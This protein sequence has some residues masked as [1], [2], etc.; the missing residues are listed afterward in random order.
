[1]LEVD[2]LRLSQ[3]ISNLLINAGKYTERAGRIT[4]TAGREGKEVV[5]RV[6][7]TGIGIAPELLPR[8]FDLFT[9][10]ARSLDRSQGGLGLGLTVVKRMVELHGGTVTALSEGLGKGTELVVRLPALLNEE[11]GSIQEEQ[12]GQSILPLASH[13]RRILVV[14]DNVDAAETLALLLRLWGHEVQT[15]RD[16][17][18]ALKVAGHFAPDVMLLDIGL[19][20]VSGLELAKQFR[21]QPEFQE[22]LLIAMTGYGREEDHQR[23]L[24]AGFDAHLTKPVPLAELHRLLEPVPAERQ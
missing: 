6:K 20:E 17:R 13:P 22:T 3:V 2:V 23:S 7:D 12:G 15:V 24:E 16:S 9:Q 14:E 18:T 10:E 4:L 19:P 8:I 5:I 1:M 21:K 11:E